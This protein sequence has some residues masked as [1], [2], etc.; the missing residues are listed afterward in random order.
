MSA[1]A[2][3]FNY[4]VDWSMQKR[5]LVVGSG[6]DS[7]LDASSFDL[8]Y[9]ANSSFT[10]VKN[11]KK[12]SLIL[13]DAMLFTSD[14]LDRHAPIPGL[15]RLASN[16]FRLKKCSTIDDQFFEKILVL[17][18]N[19]IDIESALKRKNVTFTSLKKLSYKDVWTLIS[20]CFNYYEL[21]TIFINVPGV[22]NKIKF[23]AQR[24]LNKKMNIC[25]RPSAGINAIMVAHSENPGA[26][27]YIS[28]INIYSDMGVRQSK[29]S[30]G[31]ITHKDNIHLLDPLYGRLLREKNVNVLN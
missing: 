10:R 28:G 14:I 2:L 25:Y 5:V 31:D 26:D 23:L 20:F 6:D 13:S 8:V 22:Q 9:S 24:F 27:I 30:T 3:F 18:N 4:L 19:Y 15:D 1:N 11:Y 7:V 17:D 12:I 21:M 29:Y 16:T